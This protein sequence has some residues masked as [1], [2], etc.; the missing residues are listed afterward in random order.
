[1]RIGGGDIQKLKE[2]ARRKKIMCAPSEFF[3]RNRKVIKNRSNGL[4]KRYFRTLLFRNDL[5]GTGLTQN[6]KNQKE[7]GSTA[8]M[9]PKKSSL[10]SDVKDDYK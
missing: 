8:P 10:R 4:G 9:K 7:E 6:N 2:K 1:M 3:G 5:E